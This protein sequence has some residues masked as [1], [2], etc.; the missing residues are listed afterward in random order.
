MPKV[1]LHEHLD[2]GLREQTLLELC[3]HAACRCPAPTRPAWPLVRRAPMPAAWAVP[4]RFRAHG[5]GDG[6][7]AALR[8]VAFE[9]AEDARA[10]GCVL[11]EFRIAPLL[12]E[13]TACAARPRSRRCLPAC[14]AAPCPAA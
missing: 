3:A 1:L 7:P 4:A 14:G 8:R 10:D 9:A 5:G 6:Q 13:R 11:A 2:G 12:F